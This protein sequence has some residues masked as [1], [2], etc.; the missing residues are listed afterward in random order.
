MG[1]VKEDQSQDRGMFTEQLKGRT[2]QRFFSPSEEENFTYPWAYS[3]FADVHF[4]LGNLYQ[5]P[6]ANNER[7]HFHLKKAEKLYA[8]LEDYANSARARQLLDNQ[9]AESLNLT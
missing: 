5:S 6:L 9:R 3:D 2:Q 4:M 7:S 8:K 1:G